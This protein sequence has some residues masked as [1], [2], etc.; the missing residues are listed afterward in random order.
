MIRS[1]TTQ[2]DA[3]SAAS[4]SS[5][6]ASAA[7][8]GTSID[9]FVPAGFDYGCPGNATVSPAATEPVLVASGHAYCRPPRR[10]GTRD[11]GAR[12]LGRAPPGP[13]RPSLARRAGDPALGPRAPRRVS[14]WARHATAT[15]PRAG[16]RTRIGDLRRARRPQRRD[17]PRPDRD[18][19]ARR[20]TRSAVLCRNHRYFFEITG[21][22]AKL[23]ANALYLN[24]GFAAPQVARCCSASGPCCSC[25][26][27]SSTRSRQRRTSSRGCSPGPTPSTR[28]TTP[29]R[30]TTSPTATPTVPRSRDPTAPGARSS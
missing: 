17:R 24:T 16:R 1:T 15:A 5:T 18:R 4:T 26:T 20:A 2:P 25:T 19:R 22:L 8:L 11:P 7:T 9:I 14:R 21:A 13:P 29:A 23:G 10:R 6:L 28:S 30:S 12:S 27:T 3:R